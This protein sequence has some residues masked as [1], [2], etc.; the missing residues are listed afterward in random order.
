MICDL[1][2]GRGLFLYEPYST[3]KFTQTIAFRLFLLLVAVQAAG[4][5]LHAFAAIHVQES[6]LMEDV[7]LGATRVSNMIRLATQHSMMLNRKE[8]VEGIIGGVASEPGIEGIRIY[9]KVGEV[10][11]TTLPA[12]RHTKVDMNAEACVSCHRT[13]GL[14]APPGVTENLSRIIV[15]PDGERVLGLITP[16]RNEAT[17]ANAD[18]HAHPSNKTILGVLDVKMSLASADLHIAE[19]KHQLFLLS[20]AAVLIIGLVSGGFIWHEVRRPV[21]RLTAGMNRVSSGDL[22]H[23]LPAVSRDELGRLAFTFNAMTEELSRARGELTAWSETLEQKVKQKTDDLERAHRE[24]VNVEKMASLGNLASSVAHELNNPLEGILT[25]ARLL[26][27]RIDKSNL[28][29]EE[30]QSYRE[31]LTLMADEA[32]RCGNIVKN[33][34]VFAR[35]RGVSH[36]PVQLE[37]IVRRCG[38]LLN[39]HAK[40][41]NVELK[42]SSTTDES[43]ECDP[44]QIQQVLIV[45]MMNAIEAMGTGINRAE[46]GVLSVAVSGVEGKEAVEIAVSDTGIGMREETKAHMFE[47]FFTT[48]SEGKGVGLGLAVA[49]GIIQRHHGSIG[50]TSAAGKG[51]TFTILLP[52]RQPADRNESPSMLEGKRT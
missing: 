51:T 42:V 27:K 14:E 19:S 48:K 11:F 16:I 49:Y 3:V 47:P 30:I 38:L 10:V 50:V 6:T 22:D 12:D 37:P 18:C 32:L 8:D 31:D 9:N 40:M 17:C 2:T 1:S 52:V 43:V 4:V 21:K 20:V 25:F 44:D 7:L 24:M 15:K 39:H 36:Q 41:H 13:N 28:T 26:L 33:L 35:Q 5:A 34:L 23:R 45:L 29:P 46:G